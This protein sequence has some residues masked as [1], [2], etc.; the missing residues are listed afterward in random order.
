MVKFYW[1]G[2]PEYPEKITDLSQVRDKLYHIMLNIVIYYLDEK[3]HQNRNLIYLGHFFIYIK[4]VLFVD[5]IQEII[6]SIFCNTQTLHCIKSTEH[7]YQFTNVSLLYK[8][9]IEMSGSNL[10]LFTRV[11]PT[12]P[13]SV[14]LEQ[15]IHES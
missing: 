4:I 10:A 9:T 6:M 2:K 8:D 1:W 14:C 3:R 11:T 13:L 7:Y 12:D 5:S 15:V